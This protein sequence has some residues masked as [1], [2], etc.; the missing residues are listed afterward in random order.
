VRNASTKI[1]IDI[2]KLSGCVNEEELATLP[3]FKRNAL[4]EK[5]KKVKVEKNLEE[6]ASRAAAANKVNISAI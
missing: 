5:I 6:S 2:Q 3:E 4:M 1:L